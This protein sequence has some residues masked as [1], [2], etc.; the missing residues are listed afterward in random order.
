MLGV[1]TLGQDLA[2]ARDRAYAV[3]DRIAWPEG[4]RRRDIG[5]AR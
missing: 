3:V 5:A 1:T 4:F 2:A